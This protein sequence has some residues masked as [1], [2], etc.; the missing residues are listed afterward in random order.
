[1]TVEQRLRDSSEQL[2]IATD[3]LRVPQ[4]RFERDPLRR[5]F[6]APAVAFAIIAV[7]LVVAIGF[8]AI[9]R[10]TDTEERLTT[11]SPPTT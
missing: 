1:M 5:E 2:R 4:P 8:A 11:V 9:N 3:S 7:A 10:D 6:G